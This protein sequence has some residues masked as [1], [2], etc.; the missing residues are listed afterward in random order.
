M[1]W[2]HHTWP[3]QKVSHEMK[4]SGGGIGPVATLNGLIV[5]AKSTF[6][7]NN[8]AP[9]ICA[10]MCGHFMIWPVRRPVPGRSRTWRRRRAGGLGKDEFRFDLGDG[11]DRITDFT[12]GQD[13]IRILAAD[14][15]A[16]LTFVVKGHDVQID[17]RSIHIL[18]Q[19][20]TLAEL[21]Q[22]V[23]FQF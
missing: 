18:V 5:T 11:K 19:D 9:T 13:V 10:G 22:A 1:T 4:L 12:A 7:N 23:N 8:L 3:S 17:Y 6:T 2:D 15:R 21:D 14:S 20:I 16:D